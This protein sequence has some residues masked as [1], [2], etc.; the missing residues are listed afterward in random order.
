MLDAIQTNRDITF[1]KYLTM[2]I[3]AAKGMAYL[4]NKGIAHRDLAAR[5]L[6]CDKSLHV[7]VA[8][9]GLS[10]DSNYELN[11]EATIPV[12]WSA[13]EVLSG[14]MATSESDVY[15]FG[16]VMWEIVEA[17]KK[18]FVWL[19]NQEVA[20]AVIK[21]V[22]LPKPENKCPEALF[23]LMNRCWQENPTKRP[24][25]EQIIQV[26]KDIQ[27]EE[28]SLLQMNPSADAPPKDKSTNSI[29]MNVPPSLNPSAPVNSK[30]SP[31]ENLKRGSARQSGNHSGQDY[32]NFKTT[33]NANADAV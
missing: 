19:S 25:F 23:E 12:R 18:P 14:S 29:R 13:P 1:D 24:N 8:D 27:K 32:V 22:R 5:N 3:D 15:S 9:F 33:A 20:A 11:S 7:K 16:V 2:L 4:Q 6:L 26:L 17:G 10:R 31:Y 21:G 30:D 28:S